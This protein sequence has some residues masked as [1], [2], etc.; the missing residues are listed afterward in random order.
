MVRS[1]NSVSLSILS[2]ILVFFAVSCS[3]NNS[4]TTEEANETIT[5]TYQTLL[6][7]DPDPEGLKHLQVCLKME[8]QLK[9][10][11]IALKIQKNIKTSK[12]YSFH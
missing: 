11:K 10:L 7:R 8:S 12:K 9:K 4:F 2:T 5:N 3:N 6:K 1:F